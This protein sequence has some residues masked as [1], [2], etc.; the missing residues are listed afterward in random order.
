MKLTFEAMNLTDE[1]LRQFLDH[2][3]QSFTRSG[4]NFAL[5]F[6]YSF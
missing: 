3:T 4:R 5:G 2:R 6:N 1:R